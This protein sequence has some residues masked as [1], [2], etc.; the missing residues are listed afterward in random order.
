MKKIILLI[1]LSFGLT[2]TTQAQQTGSFDEVVMF[3]Q[4]Q[5]TLAVHVPTDYNSENKYNLIIGLHGLGDTGTNYRNG[6]IS[7]LNWNTELPNTIFVFP[8]GGEDQSSDHYAPAGDEQFIVEAMN[9]AKANYNIDENEIILQ[10]FSL[11]GRSALKFGLENYDL[12]KGLVLNTPAVQGVLDVNNVEGF[13]SMYQ[14]ENAPQIPIA[15]VHGSE[16]ISYLDFDIQLYQNLVENNGVVRTGILDGMGH[17]IPPIQI[18]IQLFNFIDNPY[19]DGI[20]IDL[21]DMEMP[22]RTC[23]SSAS[24]TLLLRNSGSSNSG[25]VTLNINVNGTDYTHTLDID[26]GAFESEMLELDL[27]DI[28]LQEGLNDFVVSVKSIEKGEDIAPASDTADASITMYSSPITEP[29]NIGF[30]QGEDYW[31]DW[32]VDES[33]SL[34]PWWLES[35]VSKSGTSSLSKVSTILLFATFGLE[36]DFLTPYFD[37]TQ[38]EN[39]SV[40][41]DYAFNYHKYTP[42]YFTADVTFSDTLRIYISNDCGETYDLLYEKTEAELATAAEPITNALNVQSAIF[43]PTADEWKTV[44]IDLSDYSFESNS[45]L[46]FTMVSGQGGVMYLDNVKIGDVSTSVELTEETNSFTISPNPAESYIEIDDIISTTDAVYTINSMT[47]EELMKF[48]SNEIDNINI[49]KLSSGTYFITKKV[50][51]K[52]ETQKFIKR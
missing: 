39:K 30:E 40:S 41:F 24:P 43:I 31:E 4:E 14:Y 35:E 50:S 37:L 26:F 12:F 19:R 10:G 34:F 22:Q 3:N 28:P 20:D 2:F 32:Y 1:A 6:L 36:E 16:D 7:S 38:Y 13:S 51:N 33:G 46:K 48:N 5:R 15:I 52:T 23:E 8:D 49:E 42:P 9:W 27:A 25:D 29:I 21:V 17:T 11:G 47:G 44:T 45:T 18:M